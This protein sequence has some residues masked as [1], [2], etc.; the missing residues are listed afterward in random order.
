MS[1]PTGDLVAARNTTD[2]LDVLGFH[3]PAWMRNA[4][5][6]SSPIDFTNE[7]VTSASKALQ[8]CA[9]CSLMATCRA[10]ALADPDLV[11]IWG[12]TDSAARRAMRRNH[13]ASGQ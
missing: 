11:G 1:D 13:Q 2:A 12:G 4:S 3:R 8:I 9:R 5:C 7:N 10:Y 6:K